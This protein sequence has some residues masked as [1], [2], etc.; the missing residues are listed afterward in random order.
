[1]NQTS[2]RR[3]ILA[4]F[5]FFLPFPPVFLIFFFVAFK[6]G[7]S[8]YNFSSKWTYIYERKLVSDR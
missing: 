7:D 2:L 3:L 5:Y 8:G 1:M 6:D 4:F